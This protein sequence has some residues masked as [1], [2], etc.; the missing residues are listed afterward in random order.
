[1]APIGLQTEDGVGE[2]L[3]GRSNQMKAAADSYFPNIA[4]RFFLQ[5]IYIPGL[6]NFVTLS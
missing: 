2:I 6:R 4:A 5:H 3:L 1:L